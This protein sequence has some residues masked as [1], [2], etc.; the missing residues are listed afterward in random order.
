MGGACQVTLGIRVK[1]V[2]DSESK[3]TSGETNEVF[4]HFDEHFDEHC[5]IFPC[6]FCSSPRSHEWP[7]LERCDRCFISEQASHGAIG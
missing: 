3:N 1:A 7:L 4:E 5:D 2:S 6:L